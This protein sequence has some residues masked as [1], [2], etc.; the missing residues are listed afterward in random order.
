MP[1]KGATAEEILEG[2]PTLSK[3]KIDVATLY[4]VFPRVP[5]C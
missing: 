2:Y 1:A 5:E 3:Q 4:M